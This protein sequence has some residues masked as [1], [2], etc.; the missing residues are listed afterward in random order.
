VVFCFSKKNKL[1]LLLTPLSPQNKKERIFSSL[2]YFVGI[3]IL[4]TALFLFSFLKS[5]YN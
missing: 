3:Y 1:T 5:K 4:N 2:F